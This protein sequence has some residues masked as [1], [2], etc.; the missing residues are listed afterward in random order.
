MILVDASL[1]GLTHVTAIADHSWFSLLPHDLT[2]SITFLGQNAAELKK[3]DIIA[4]VQKSFKNFVESGQVWAL[5]I[6]LVLGWLAHSFVG[7]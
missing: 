6:G 4:D 1:L 7:S 5:G 2:D 3:V